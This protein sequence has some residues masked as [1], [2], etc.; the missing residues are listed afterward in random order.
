MS[1]IE[2]RTEAIAKELCKERGMPLG[3]MELLLHDAYQL[4]YF[5]DKKELKRIEDKIKKR[6]KK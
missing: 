3:M 6:K 2:K 1:E 5:G 4:V